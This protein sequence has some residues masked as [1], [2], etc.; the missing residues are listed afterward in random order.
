MVFLFQDDIISVMG[1]LPVTK[2][3]KGNATVSHLCSNEYQ[4]IANF[5]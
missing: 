4:N 5:L 3:F 1:Y 2:N